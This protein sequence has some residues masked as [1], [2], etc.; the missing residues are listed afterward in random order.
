MRQ[1]LKIGAVVLTVAALTMSGIALAQSDE[2]TDDGAARPAVT[3][4]MERLQDLVTDGT[5]SSE[6][7]EAVAQHLADGVRM[8]RQRCHAG[9][10]FGAI[11]EF[12]EMEPEEFRA[13]LQ[14]FDTLAALAA[15]NGSSGDE[16]I[17]FLVAQAEQRLAQAVE[18]GRIDQATADEKLAQIEDAVTRMVNGELPEWGTCVGRPGHRSGDGPGPAE[19][20]F[21]RGPGGFGAPEA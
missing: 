18:N 10:G 5:I 11:A 1:T 17:E 7:A 16:V 2:S 12:L 9:P 3:K 4:I 15:A 6:Q 14:E 20:G 13:A 8:H 21:G 19:Q